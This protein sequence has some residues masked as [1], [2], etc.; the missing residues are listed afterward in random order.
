MDKNKLYSLLPLLAGFFWGLTGIFV[1]RL[2]GLGI[3]NLHLTFFRCSI[4]ALAIIVYYLIKDKKQLKIAPKDLWCFFGTGILSVFTFSVSYFYTL[5]HASI[6]VAVILSYTA[7]FFV[8]ILSAI[9]FKEKITGVKIISLI[10]ATLGCF[11]LCGTDTNTKITL[12]IVAVGLCSGLA[13][14][15]YSIFSKF[16]VDKYPPL[17]ITAYTFIF[18]SCGSVFLVDFGKFA[19][20]VSVSPSSLL[21]ITLF[22]LVSTLLPYTL[23]TVGLRHIEPGKAAILTTMEVLTASLC[24]IFIFGEKITAAGILGIL[25]ILAAVILLNIKS[26]GK[27]F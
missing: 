18:A 13:Y 21:Y 3:N 20:V 6:S 25:L 7:P 27:K 26:I 19:E 10:M 23:L 16:V 17:I 5:I 9:L 12:L 24:G 8:M 1:R 2:N 22:A 11:L 15:S 4:S 14:A